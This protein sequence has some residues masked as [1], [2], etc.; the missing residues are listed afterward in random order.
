MTRSFYFLVGP[1]PLTPAVGW[2]L[3]NNLHHR[4]RVLLE[5]AKVGRRPT[6][7]GYYEGLRLYYCYLTSA[8]KVYLKFLAA[9]G[10]SAASSPLRAGLPTCRVSYLIIL[11]FLLT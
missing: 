8:V 9:I 10:R 3:A 6:P 7:A 5:S 4:E 1:I 2:L 11:F